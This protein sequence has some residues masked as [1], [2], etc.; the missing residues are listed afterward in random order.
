MPPLI[1]TSVPAGPVAGE[2]ASRAALA[3]TVKVAVCVAVPTVTEMVC[4]PA[5]TPCGMVIV[6]VKLPLVL[7]FTSPDVG[8]MVVV[9]NLK[10]IG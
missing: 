2:S 1:C 7:V 4:A 10:M 5:V 3:V 9:S 8:V 6:L